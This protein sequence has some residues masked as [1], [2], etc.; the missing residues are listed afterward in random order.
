MIRSK[1]RGQ[2]VP[3]DTKKRSAPAFTASQLFA[4]QLFEETVEL[5]VEDGSSNDADRFTSFIIDMLPS[6][7]LETL[8][9][10]A[11]HDDD[12]KEA[13]VVVGPTDRTRSGYHFQDVG[14]LHEVWMERFYV[15]P[16][17][18]NDGTSPEINN[19]SSYECELCDR[20]IT[21]TF[22]HVYPKETHTW[23]RSR[24]PMRYTDMV[25]RTTINLCRMCHR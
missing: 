16:L 19:W 1:K 11:G 4:S 5:A 12:T 6:E 14:F 10:M 17:E 20:V 7:V 3:G 22:H 23:L 2:K 13:T 9:D 18:D 21:T 8:K 25:L 15:A 24:D